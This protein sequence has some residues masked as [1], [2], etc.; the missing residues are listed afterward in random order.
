MSSGRK[1][2]GGKVAGCVFH[3]IYRWLL[4]MSRGS[5][6][7]RVPSVDFPRSN[8]PSKSMSSCRLFNSL[9]FFLILRDGMLVRGGFSHREGPVGLANP[10]AVHVFASVLAAEGPVLVEDLFG[11]ALVSRK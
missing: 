8:S 5:L 1:L 3:P 4:M 10:G 11:D 6:E 9:A 2:V 7:R